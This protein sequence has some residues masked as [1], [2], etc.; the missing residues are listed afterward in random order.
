MES[1]NTGLV[2]TFND[3]DTSF[4]IKSTNNKSIRRVMDLDKSDITL[5][6]FRLDM[7]KNSDD[8]LK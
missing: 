1:S 5:P 3:R 7:G 6:E 8:I 2:D 4:T